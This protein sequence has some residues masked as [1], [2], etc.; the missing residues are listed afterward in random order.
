MESVGNQT[1]SLKA[2][3][4]EKKDQRRVLLIYGRDDA[5]HFTIDQQES[6]NEFRDQLEERD[7]DVIVLIA[8]TVTEP[9]RWYLMHSDFKLNPAEDFVGWLVGKDGT[10]KTSFTSPMAPQELFRIIDDMPMRQ[11]E[12]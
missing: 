4:D 7:T 2:I 10:V 6:L 3:L 1:K 9:D 11:Q 5:Q 8:S 12:K